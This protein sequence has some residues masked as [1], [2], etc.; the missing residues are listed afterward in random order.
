MQD[1][2]QWTHYH[3]VGFSMGGMIASKMAAQRSAA[4]L[5]LTLISSSLGGW[6]CVPRSFKAFRYGIGML[7]A[8]TAEKRAHMDIRFHFTKAT[9]QK[10]VRT[11]RLCSAV[12]YDAFAGSCDYECAAASACC[13]PTLRRSVLTWTYASTLRKRRA[14]SGCAFSLCDSK[15]AATF[16][17]C[18]LTLRRSALA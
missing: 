10:W 4:V 17:S 12:R 8:D 6:A 1:A 5:S 9:R 2:L 18:A 13:T 11:A 15:C 14:R 16:T 3:V 7:R